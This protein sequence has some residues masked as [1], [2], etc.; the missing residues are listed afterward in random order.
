MKKITA[1][2][3]LILIIT[4]I[5]Q[6]SRIK[7]LNKE[8]NVYKG[9]TNALMSDIE[10]FQIDSSRTAHVVKGLQ[11][12]LGEYEEYRAEDLQTIKDL[13]L[14][15]KDIE[16]T[17]KTKL[18][19]KDHILAAL[20]DTIVLRD[21]MMVAAKKVQSTDEYTNFTGIIV[22]DSLKADYQTIVELDQAFYTTYKWK[23]LWFKGPIK[24]VRQVII[25]PNKKVELKYSEY[26]KIR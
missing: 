16:A 8:V 22:N 21:S 7:E 20:E 19:I 12:T 25:T 1:F 11:F 14:K 10:K 4:M 15:V 2:V 9:N 23:F 3:L 6:H 18:E 26:I 17:A 24:D 5:A 13:K